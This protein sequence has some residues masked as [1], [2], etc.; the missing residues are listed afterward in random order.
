MRFFHGISNR[1]DRLLHYYT[2]FTLVDITATGMT[3]GEVCEAR[4]QQSNWETVLQTIG[5]LAQPMSITEPVRL[6]VNLD[7]LE[8]GNMFQGHHDIWAWSFGVEHADVFADQNSA[9]GRLN[10]CFDQVPVIC[11]LQET[12]RFILPIFFT[13]GGIKNIYF[14]EGQ[15]DLNNI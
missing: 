6:K 8:F 3:R 14:K 5:L 15:K 7:Y 13:S 4:N 2:G 9:I 12:A 10:Q 11:G 1:M